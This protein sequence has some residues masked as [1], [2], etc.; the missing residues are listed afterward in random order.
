VTLNVGPDPV[1]LW[2]A[3]DKLLTEA[4]IAASRE[5]IA[6]PIFLQVS[7]VRSDD[8]S[9]LAGR[10]T[11]WKYARFLG[12]TW[13]RRRRHVCITLE[14]F[15]PDGSRLLDSAISFSAT[16]KTL[17]AVNLDGALL[18]WRPLPIE[19]VASRKVDP[20]GRFG[21]VNVMASICE[22]DRPP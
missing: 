21:P 14:I 16:P 3:E 5:Y 12:T 2:E 1:P 4:V 9:A 18:G 8:A 20:R 10:V 6:S 11:M 22:S 19:P 7:Y 13:L 15:R 17:G